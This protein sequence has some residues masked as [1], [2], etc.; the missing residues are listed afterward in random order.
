MHSMDDDAAERRVW[1]A[2]LRVL[3]ERHPRATWAQGSSAAARFWLDVHEG[4][5][6]QCAALRSATDAYRSQAITVLAYAALVAPLQRAMVAHLAGHHQIEDYHYFPLFRAWQPR[7]AAGFDAL[8]AD[9]EQLH[10]TI[11]AALAALGSFLTAAHSGAE[12]ESAQRHAAERYIVSSERLYR[13][14]LHHLEDEE[15][16]IIPLLLERSGDL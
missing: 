5:R 12:H 9:H 14:L 13:R 7:I 15:D 1:P 6:R 10:L 4:F 11:D 2:E 3:L 8:A 16:L